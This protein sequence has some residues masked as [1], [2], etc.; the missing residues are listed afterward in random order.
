MIHQ[1]D[2]LIQNDMQIVGTESTAGCF[3]P[4]GVT[5]VVSQPLISEV[6]HSSLISALENPLNWTGLKTRQNFNFVPLLWEAGKPPPDKPP[7]SCC[8]W[9]GWGWGSREGWSL[10]GCGA[11]GRGGAWLGVGQLG[12]VEHVLQVGGVPGS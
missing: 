10:A 3:R 4:A 9:H 5:L 11:A 2:V 1:Y 12:G 8:L 6:F 7:F